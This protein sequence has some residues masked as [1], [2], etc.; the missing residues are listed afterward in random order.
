VSAYQLEIVPGDRWCAYLAQLDTVFKAM[1]SRRQNMAIRRYTGIRPRFD[2]PPDCAIS[3]GHRL[4]FD[5]R[6]QI[7]KPARSWA[8]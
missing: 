4:F 3:L 7:V 2:M 5:L 1:R 6:E 8:S